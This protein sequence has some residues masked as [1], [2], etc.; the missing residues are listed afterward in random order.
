MKALA[1][2]TLCLGLHLHSGCTKR[3][4]IHDD[5]AHTRLLPSPTSWMSHAPAPSPN[6]CSLVFGDRNAVICGSVYFVIE[7]VELCHERSVHPM[8]DVTIDPCVYTVLRDEESC[9]S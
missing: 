9:I 6:P 1:G 3:A 2:I 5:S 7:E 4:R 8:T